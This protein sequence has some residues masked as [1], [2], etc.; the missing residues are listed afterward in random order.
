[1]VASARVRR[2]LGRTLKRVGNDRP[3]SLATIWNDLPDDARR[4][5]AEWAT[6]ARWPWHDAVAWIATRDATV[7][8]HVAT[9][10]AFADEQVSAGKWNLEVAAG[11][12]L[13]VMRDAL[14]DADLSGAARELAQALGRGGLG[15]V[16]RERGRG[17]PVPIPAATWDRF[18]FI[19]ANLGDIGPRGGCELWFGG[20]MVDGVG[21]L[22]RWP[23]VTAGNAGEVERSS[24]ASSEVL[25]VNISST[26]P[27]TLAPARDV[28]EWLRQTY[29]AETLPHV[30]K[31]VYPAAREEFH[32]KRGRRVTRA[33]IEKGVADLG[34][35]RDQGR[36]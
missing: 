4:A 16:G 1:M 20:V 3:S 14:Q 22:A 25:N 12:V 36:R 28:K 27:P 26:R 29:V 8:Q 7:M 33:M 30:A 21:V 24:A 31:S 17:F 32:N 23:S 13:I 5:G 15:A 2:C 19:S 11:A 9:Y 18:A 34:W 6:R 35:S 10:R